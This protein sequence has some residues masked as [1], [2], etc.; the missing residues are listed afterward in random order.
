MPPPPAG[1]VVPQYT[2]GMYTYQQPYIRTQPFIVPYGIAPHLAAK[3]MQA[4]AAFRYKVDLDG[5]YE[6]TITY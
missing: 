2:P 3:M 6:L 4:S 5:H 1:F